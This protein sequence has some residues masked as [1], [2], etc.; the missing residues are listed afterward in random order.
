MSRIAL[1]IWLSTDCDSWLIPG[2][3]FSC[4]LGPN[5]GAGKAHATPLRKHCHE[6]DGRV[7]GIVHPAVLP[8]F[9]LQAEVGQS[10][11]KP[12]R[13]SSI[14]GTKHPA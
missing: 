9:K 1:T 4:K 8:A 7:D 2:D 14:A 3:T 12:L 5:I 10:I 6:Q 11:V 13:L